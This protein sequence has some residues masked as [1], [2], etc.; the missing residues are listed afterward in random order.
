MSLTALCT[1]LTYREFT[2]TGAPLAGGKL[3]TAQPGTV[4][5]PAQASPKATYTD[6]T[7]ATP[8]ANPVVLDAAGRA[9]VWLLGAYSMALYD[10]NGVLIKSKDQV[11]GTGGG[12]DV[13]TYIYADAT[14]GLY[15]ANILAANDPAAPGIYEIS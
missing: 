2:N 13:T 9:D 1:A 15:N 11:T 8:N 14:A 4:A 5:G 7:G 6:G 12:L 10:A 3:Y